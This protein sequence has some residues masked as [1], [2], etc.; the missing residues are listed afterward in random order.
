M[1]RLF[2]ALVLLV[3]LLPGC[4][5]DKEKNDILTP[6]KRL[7]DKRYTARW[8]ELYSSDT[9]RLVEGSKESGGGVN[10]LL[11]M[12]DGVE[13]RAEVLSR[14]EKSGVLR[15]TVLRHPR[16]NMRGA[17]MEVPMVLENG[18]WRF[19]LSGEVRGGLRVMER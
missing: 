17:V 14:R 18:L 12:G 9:V 13:Y 11:P 15:L 8:K 1:G 19:D 10:L 5:P 4:K 7:G 16:E 6:V 2:P 3:C